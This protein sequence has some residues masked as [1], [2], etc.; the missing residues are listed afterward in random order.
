ML[1]PA[2]GAAS[3]CNCRAFRYNERPLG[4]FLWEA[5]D[6]V[7]SVAWEIQAGHVETAELVVGFLFW[8][9]APPTIALYELAPICMARDPFGVL[10]SLSFGEEVLPQG[11]DERID[12][13]E[14]VIELLSSLNHLAWR[15]MF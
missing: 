13:S 6:A 14:F 4:T 1:S 2:A 15:G 9:L 8:L 12:P 3:G 11:F 5:S 7:A 10:K